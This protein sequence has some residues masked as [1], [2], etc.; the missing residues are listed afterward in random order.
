MANEKIEDIEDEFLGAEL[1][2]SRRAQRLLRL[3]KS[4][5]NKPEVSFPSALPPSELEAAYRFFGSSA[6]SSEAIIAPHVHQTLKRVVSQGVTLVAHDSSVIS[7]KTE[8]GRDGLVGEAGLKQ[9]FLAH[10]SLAIRADGSDRPEGVV[11]L[12]YHRPVKTKNAALQQ[13]WSAHIEETHSLGMSLRDVAHLM[14]READDYSV[15]HLRQRLG[16]RF[17]VRVQHNRRLAQGKLRDVLEQE[18]SG[19]ASRAV[20]LSRRGGKLG[21]KQRKRHPPRDERMASLL[22]TSSSVEIAKD[23]RRLTEGSL[24]LNVVS[25]W[26]PEPPGDEKGIEWLLYTSEPVDNPEQMFQVVDWYRARWCIEEYFKALKQG[27]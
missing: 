9:R 17:V 19:R 14:E 4:M 5:A 15:L 2:D 22:V 26:E 13:R 1:G 23:P 3:A 16:T 21:S 25:V 24:K 10:C 7:F 11:A 27:C 18:A 12:S 8:T 6:V 20:K